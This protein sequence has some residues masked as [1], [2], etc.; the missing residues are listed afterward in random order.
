VW[1]PSFCCARL[2]PRFCPE[3]GQAVC[4]MIS[5]YSFALKKSTWLFTWISVRTRNKCQILRFETLMA[6]NMKTAILWDMTPCILSEVFQSFRRSV[7]RRISTPKIRV[8]DPVLTDSSASYLG[9]QHKCFLNTFISPLWS[10][11]GRYYT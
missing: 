5:L 8:R 11:V 3:L 1:R 2:N 4:H 6:L 10:V 9:R 7:Y